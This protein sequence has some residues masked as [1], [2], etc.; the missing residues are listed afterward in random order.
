VS[1]T[2]DELELLYAAIAAANGQGP[3][4]GSSGKPTGEIA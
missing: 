2:E 4:P 3:E 1:K